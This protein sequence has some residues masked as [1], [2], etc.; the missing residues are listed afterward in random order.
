MYFGIEF[1]KRM[2]DKKTG[3][4]G[5]FKGTKFV[6][7]DYASI[8]NEISEICRLLKTPETSI[9]FYAF[10]NGLTYFGKIYAT[11]ETMYIY[12]F[13]DYKTIDELSVTNK[14]SNVK[15]FVIRMLN[16]YNNYVSEHS[17]NN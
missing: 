16:R 12:E 13:D 17:E 14:K 9:A 6:L 3:F 8:D 10:D 5:H 7:T 1:E 2:T 4:S 15:T 11:G